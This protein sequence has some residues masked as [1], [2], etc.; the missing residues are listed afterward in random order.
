MASLSKKILQSSQLINA[1]NVNKE[2]LFFNFI[3]LLF[4]CKFNLRVK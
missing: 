1:V 2:F 4:S 3:K